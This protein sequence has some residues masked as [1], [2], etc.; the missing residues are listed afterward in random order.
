MTCGQRTDLNPIRTFASGYPSDRYSNMDAGRG[1]VPIDACIQ[2]LKN[3]V[4][5]FKSN[6]RHDGGLLI[7]HRR[8]VC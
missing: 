8:P 5:D 2:L 4:A 3:Y 1:H 6:Y 7:I